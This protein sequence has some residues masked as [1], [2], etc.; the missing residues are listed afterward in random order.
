MIHHYCVFLRRDQRDE[1]EAIESQ[2]QTRTD[3][4]SNC[5]KKR[6]RTEQ[7]ANNHSPELIDLT[8]IADHE[9]SASVR[10]LDEIDPRPYLDS[11]IIIDTSRFV[12]SFSS[13]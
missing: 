3:N 5:R 13:V 2:N 4:R 11:S 1:V 9:D 7:A 10:V 12:F 6:R 8:D